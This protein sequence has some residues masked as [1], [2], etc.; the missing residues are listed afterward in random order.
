MF[1]LDSNA[2]IRF[3]N[4]TSQALIER[5]R[6]TPREQVRLSPI[7]KAELVYG[8]R[9]SA[10]AADNIRLLR[11]FFGAFASIPFD[12]RAAEE[13]GLIR[14]A[15]ERAG[16]PIGPYDLLIAATARAHELTL[17]THNKREFSRILGLEI[18]D[19]EA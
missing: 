16:T 3:L 13:A 11:R 14:V 9:R 7:V 19:W 6:S 17:V 1:L 18:E 4:G 5:L 2:C 12:D 10:R 8:A 15:L